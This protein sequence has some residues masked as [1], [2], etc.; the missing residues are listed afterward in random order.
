[1]TVEAM[2]P[3]AVD[4]TICSTAKSCWHKVFHEYFLNWKPKGLSI[5]LHAGAAFASG[6]EAAKQNFYVK[7]LSSED[8]VALGLQALLTHYGDFECPP[9]SAKSAQ[10]MA[11]AL[12]FY[13]SNYPLGGDGAEPISLPGGRR[14][15]EV[16]FAE[17]LPIA[18]PVTG[19]PIL[20]VG[21][22]DSAVHYA[23]GLYVEDDK[24]TSQL[25]ALWGR[26]WDLRSQFRGYAWGLSKAAGVKPTGILV[27]GVAIRKQ[28]YDTEQ[29]ITYCADWQI[30][31]WFETTCDVVNEMVGRWKSGYWRKTLDHACNDYGGCS[32][33]AP[34]LSPNPEGHFD[35][36]FEQRK[37]D[38]IT[39]TETLLK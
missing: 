38:P 3:E 34:C 11:G 33:R 14:G 16:S 25:G 27:R 17:P 20:Y 12:E 19:N 37:W 2:F 35:T 28:G 22:L 9:T 10:R 36:H 39:R 23:Q 4:S 8:S 13:F 29:A 24:T 1:M 30:D 5:H 7:G 32:L 21:R 15:I 31:E 26:Q 18:H 6:I